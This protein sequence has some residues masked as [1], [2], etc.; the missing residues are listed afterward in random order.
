MLK[1]H[2]LLVCILLIVAHMV[3]RI[4]AYTPS[5]PRSYYLVDNNDGFYLKGRGHG[6]N[7]SLASHKMNISIGPANNQ[8]PPTSSGAPEG[9]KRLDSFHWLLFPEQRAPVCILGHVSTID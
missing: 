8:V 3:S 1:S 4:G 5:D 2:Y 9:V 7:V 6:C